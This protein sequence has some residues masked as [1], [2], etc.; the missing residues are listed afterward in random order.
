M[1]DTP[2]AVAER[3]LVIGPRQPVM[4]VSQKP[5]PEAGSITVKGWRKRVLQDYKLSP[6]AVALT[7]GAQAVSRFFEVKWLDQPNEAAQEQPAA[8]ALA[9][10]GQTVTIVVA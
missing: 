6:A 7:L 10:T 9:L 8:R 4:L 3:A 1:A 2:I 5:S